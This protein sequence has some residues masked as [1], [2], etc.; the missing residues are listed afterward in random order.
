MDRDPQVAHMR[1]SE[2]GIT[3]RLLLVR[4]GAAVATTTSSAS[5]AWSLPTL[6]GGDY[7]VTFVPPESSGYRAGWTIGTAWTQSG[8]DPWQ[9]HLPKAAP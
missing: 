1:S 8:V 5:G 3:R 9:I 2:A 6:P 7:I 4:A